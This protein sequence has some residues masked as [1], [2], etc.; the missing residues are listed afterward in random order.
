MNHTM[1]KI[2]ITHNFRANHDHQKII[3][4]DRDSELLHKYHHLLWTRM[5]KG[6]KVFDINLSINRPFYFKWGHQKLTSDSIITTFTNNKNYKKNL[7]YFEGF[8]DKE[9]VEFKNIGSTI[10]GFIIFPGT[11]SNGSLTI[12]QARGLHPRIKDRFDLTLECIRLY[13]L[14]ANIEY[15]LKY[16][17]KSYSN[18]FHL[19]K[20]FKDY[21]DFFI[22]Q[23]LVDAN[24]KEIKFWLPFKGFDNNSPLPSNSKDYQIY[25]ENVI[26]FINNRNHKINLLNL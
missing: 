16:I 8:L 26:F 6:Q 10:G 19:F 23:D 9:L 2:D 24:Y 5:F 21:I 20:N 25:K 11:K 3:D 14:E 1:D 15:P 17:L 7:S 18:F 13:Y 12:N 4:V 22:L